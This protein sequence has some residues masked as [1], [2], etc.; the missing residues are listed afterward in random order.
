MNR[1]WIEIEHPTKSDGKLIKARTEESMNTLGDE[2]AK[3]ASRMI[4]RLGGQPDFCFWHPKSGHYCFGGQMGFV[5]AT[6]N[7]H[8]FNLDFFGEADAPKP[9][10]LAYAQARHDEMSDPTP[11][12]GET[13]EQAKGRAAYYSGTDEDGL[14]SD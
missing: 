5:E 11:K 7:G 14:P 4:E 9:G 2:R 12:A 10:T 13:I 6:D 1:V 3:L 8:W